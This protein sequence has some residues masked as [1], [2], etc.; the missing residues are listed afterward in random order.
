L[1][2]PFGARKDIFEI[3]TTLIELIF[4][5][6]NLPKSR[7]EFEI[8]V[9]W[10]DWK[11]YIDQSVKEISQEF[12]IPGFRP[13]KAPQ[14]LVEQ[15]VGKGA[16]LNSASQKAVEKSYLDFVVKEKLEV[17]G[18]PEVEIEKIAE[19]QDLRY[20]ATVAVMPKGKLGHKYKARIKQIN[21]GNKSKSFAIEEKEIDLELEKL[22]NSRVK[23]VTVRREAKKND[24]V[25][26]DFSV[27]LDGRALEKGTSKNHP[28]V[29]GQG[30]FIPGFEDN[31]IG[32]AEGEEKEFTLSFPADYHE[33]KLAGQPAVFKVKM[34]LVQEREVP[35]INDAFAQSLGN[36]ADLAALKKQLR[37]NMEHEQKHKREEKIRSDYAEALAE[38]LEVELPDVLVESEAEKMTEELAGQIKA[39][40][41]DLEKDLSQ[42]KKTREDLKKDWKPQAEKRI[43]AALALKEAALMEEIQVATEEIEA[44]ANKTLQ[45][46]KKTQDA[47][48]GID[49]ERFYNYTKSVLENEKLFELLGRL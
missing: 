45:Y 15:K 33:K 26:I 8:T 30:L 46:Y 40:V 41:M 28:L 24:N 47:K 18:A 27:A 16:V 1:P 36:F 9:P 11:K 49:M 7:I 19:G 37:E 29:I 31:L 39:M 20:K 42:L 43:K 6:K 35:E 13:G 4:V 5:M 34:N 23:L 44:E 22:A 2:R 38:D 17:I 25:E 14:N 3:I 32:M 10:N 12:K 48:E 21:A